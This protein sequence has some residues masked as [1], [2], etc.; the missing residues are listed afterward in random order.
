MDLACL[1]GFF[2]L[3]FLPVDFPN[4]FF[5]FL[6][7]FCLMFLFFFSLYCFLPCLRLFLFDF[8]LPVF[9]LFCFPNELFLVLFLLPFLFCYCCKPGFLTVL[10]VLVFP[11]VFASIVLPF[12]P[13]FS[14][15][16]A[17]AYGLLP[18]LLSLPPS[19][20]LCREPVLKIND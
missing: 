1:I 13:S 7:C 6:L 8:L 15:M 14:N 20:R 11:L 5:F 19:I 18:S 2:L 12:L 16:I 4:L 9:P 10:A 3:P 17:T